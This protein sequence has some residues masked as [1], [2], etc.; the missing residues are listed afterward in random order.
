MNTETSNPDGPAVTT[1]DK[2]RLAHY[3][4]R[5]HDG[6]PTISS[7][8]WKEIK[9]DLVPDLHEAA[10][11]VGM[12]QAL[13]DLGSPA[14]LANRYREALGL[15]VH[16]LYARGAT[17]TGCLLAFVTGVAIALGWGMVAALEQAGAAGPAE[18]DFLGLGLIAVPGT[19]TFTFRSFIVPLA[20]LVVF[21]VT[22]RLW[23][24][25]PALRPKAMN[26][27]NRGYIS[28]LQ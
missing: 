19:L 9:L 2:L 6:L 27:S 28:R 12:K 11:K 3:L 15:W 23:R 4:G 5:L 1:L 24:L 17:V 10:A 16:P 25:I 26:S 8:T 18:V 20:L 21:V 14:E 22:S 7:K 13:E